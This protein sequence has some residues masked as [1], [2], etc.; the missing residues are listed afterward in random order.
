MLAGRLLRVS[1]SASW[2]M[3]LDEALLSLAPSTDQYLLRLYTW[4]KPAVTIGRFQNA[5]ACLDQRLCRDLRIDVIRR[6]TGGRAVYHATDLTYALV[7]PESAVGGASVVRSYRTI[8]L[9]MAQAFASVGLKMQE[10]TQAPPGPSSR[11]DCFAHSTISDLGI[12]GRKMIGSAQ[13][14]RRGWL[15]QQGSIRAWPIAIPP[16][17]FKT[18]TPQPCIPLPSHGLSGAALGDRLA[19]ELGK[20]LRCAW[21]DSVG[22]DSEIDLCESLVRA[23]YGSREWNWEGVVD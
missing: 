11:V 3:A 14:R 18:E 10:G 7:L 9:A 1:G 16:G 23:K 5:A 12:E 19:T 8:S 2:N 6:P 22:S 17:L 4:A 13:V 15:L 21:V 20:L